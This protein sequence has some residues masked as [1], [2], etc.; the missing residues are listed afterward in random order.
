[1]LHQNKMPRL[2]DADIYTAFASIFPGCTKN[3]RWEDTSFT[4]YLAYSVVTV[5][6]FTVHDSSCLPVGE[7]VSLGFLYR[8]N[9]G[10]LGCGIDDAVSLF[11]IKT[12]VDIVG[13]SSARSWTHNN[14]TCTHR[15]TSDGENKLRIDASTSSNAFPSFQ[16]LHAY[17]IT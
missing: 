7:S 3:A 13:L 17:K 6:W 15:R 1:M 12:T 11:S 10:F 16:S 4:S 5:T 9:P 14:P 2:S 8:Q